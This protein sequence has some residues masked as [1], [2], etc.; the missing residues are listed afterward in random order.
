MHLQTQSG[1]PK[2]KVWLENHGARICKAANTS[3]T[4]KDLKKLQTAVEE[5]RAPIR[6]RVGRVRFTERLVHRDD[7]W[8]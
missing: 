1:E 6:G 3:L 7:H 2:L 5:S 4:G 8:L